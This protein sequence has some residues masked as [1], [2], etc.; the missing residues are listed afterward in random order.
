MPVLVLFV[1]Y[2]GAQCYQKVRVGESGRNSV[3]FCIL[4]CEW[5]SSKIT[6]GGPGIRKIL[7]TK[8][9]FCILTKSYQRHNIIS[10]PY[11]FT[12]NR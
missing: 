6:A 2:L 4:A 3:L 11:V 8:T 10:H 12:V 5:S 9:Y 1:A 7:T